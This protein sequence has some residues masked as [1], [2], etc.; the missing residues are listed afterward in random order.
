VFTVAEMLEKC[1]S[2]KGPLT[3]C[4]NLF[5]V[6]KKSKDYCLIVALHVLFSAKY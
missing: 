2:D 3:F 4:K 1:K 6:N 5:I